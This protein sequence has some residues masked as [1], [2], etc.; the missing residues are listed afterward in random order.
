MAGY[1]TQ[2]WGTSGWGAPN[3]S[4]ATVANAIPRR[5][6]DTATLSDPATGYGTQ[7][8]DTSEWGYPSPPTTASA[9][10]HPTSE[11]AIATEE[12]VGY[13][14]SAWDT[15]PW[16]SGNRTVGKVTATATPQP[17]RDKP[18][19]G[20]T[21]ATAAPLSTTEVIVDTGATTPVT[22]TTLGGLG[23]GA[24][25]DQGGLTTTATTPLTAAAT[26]DAWV[27]RR[28][29]Q[30]GITWAMAHDRTLE[31]NRERSRKLVF[32]TEP[33]LD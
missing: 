18:L 31:T 10:P 13:G 8:W 16:G 32:P 11:T 21:S 7:Q 22:A 17:A 33:S 15:S 4:T 20:I 14:N 29:V 26:R 6:E 3:Q 1:G 28:H 9:T 19:E 27:Y 2:A 23:S 5:T 12:L 25:T 30:R 24:Q